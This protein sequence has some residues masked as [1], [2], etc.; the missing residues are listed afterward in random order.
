M[1]YDIVPV[2]EHEMLPESAQDFLN[3]LS[4]IKGK[5]ENTVNAYKTD[6][7]LF[8]R[9]IKV[10]KGYISPKTEFQEIPINDIDKELLKKIKLSDLYAFLSFVEKQRENG[11]HARARKV[12]CLRSYFRYLVGKVNLLDE[13][14]AEEL[15]TPKIS[16]RNPIYLSLEE[17]L[18]LL[19]SLDK[20]KKNYYRDYCILVL[21]LNCGMRVSELCGIEIAKIKED[22]LTIIGKGNKERT[23][24]LNDACLRAIENYIKVRDVS[25]VDDENKKYLFIS[26]HHRRMEK[27]TVEKLV[28]KHV[29]NAGLKNEKYTPHKLRHTAAT[30]MY[31]YGKVDIRSLQR[32]LGHESVATTQIYT[33]VDE[34]ILRDAVKANPLAEFDNKK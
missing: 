11:T 15:E 4:T 34:E 12:S 29:K 30:L 21:F 25:K 7:I 23:V 24:Y 9:F 10:Y 17:S 28:K 18:Q 14:P 6:L 13:N 26:N 27:T 32:I 1:I 20:S 33:H 19:N 3:Y 5:S 16:K 2:N 31:K 8:F 22:T